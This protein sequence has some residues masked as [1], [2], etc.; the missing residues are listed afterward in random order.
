MPSLDEIG[1]VVLEKKITCFC[2]FAIGKG[3]G[4]SFEDI[5]TPLPKSLAETDSVALEKKM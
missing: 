2:Y 5:C 3:R 4:P 1:S